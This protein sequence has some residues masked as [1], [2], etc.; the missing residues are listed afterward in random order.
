[1]EREHDEHDV[2]L[3]RRELLVTGTAT[4]AGGAALLGASRSASA[5]S[6]HAAEPKALPPGQPGRDYT[7]VVV[8]N[9]VKLP[10][11][12]VDGVKVFHLVPG[13]VDHEF[14]PGVKVR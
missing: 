1:M 11:R 6:A 14:L 3:S 7:P 12:V 2:G 8:P 9:G 5:A 10:W 13:E 4:V